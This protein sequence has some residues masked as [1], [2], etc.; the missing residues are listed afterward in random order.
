M[1][2]DR[3]AFRILRFAVFCLLTSIFYLLPNAMSPTTAY[4]ELIATLKRIAVLESTGALL[5]WDERTGMPP[6]AAA[7]RGE[8]LSLLARMTHEQF[9]DPR[10]GE[11]LAACEGTELT[12]DPESDTAANIREIRRDY[13]RATRLPGSLVAE[14]ARMRTL[15]HH[16]W[17][18]AKKASD[19]ASF[20]PTLAR[21][22]EL[23]R[24]EAACY[25]P[26]SGE[27]YDGLLEGYEPGETTA[28]LRAVFASL[29]PALVELVQKITASSRKAPLEILTRHYPIDA[30]AELSRQAAEAVGYDFQ[31]GRI[32]L[33][34][35][36]FSTGI[37]PGDV[38]I[39]TRYDEHYFSDGFFSTLHEVGHALYNQGL[40]AEHF[41][42][43]IGR[44]CSLGIHES[45][46]R[47]W[48]N[49]VGRSRAFWKLFFPRTRA[50][51]PAALEGV[52]EEAWHF[53]INDVRP[54][55]IRT[56]SD[57]LTYNL[58]ILLRFELELELLHGRL[59]TKDLPEAWNAKMRQ[60]LG[61][62][63]GCDREGVLQDVHWSSGAFGYFPTYTLGNLYAAQF[64]EQACGEIGDMDGRVETGD[65]APLLGWLR[66][67][68]HRH[69]RRYTAAQ[70]VERV[71]G[72]PLSPQPLLQHL[73]SKAAELYGV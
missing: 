10:I 34:V 54:S 3:L 25:A 64:F 38:R 47:M 20:E 27:L 50:Q 13:D 52:S 57:E 30:Q 19:Y 18:A 23:V 24:Q 31:A 5:E 21:I 11:L 22:V 66:E 56:E 62:T 43:P 58:H 70:L 48:E 73:R 12:A 17:A 9:T 59:S 6:K 42:T 14:L 16:A 4:A 55:L 29:Q 51:F 15:G 28:N 65:F 61:V 37:A 71:T 67:K 1:T 7:Y 68:I 53:A 49:L 36:P 26:A 60:Y 33:S 46:S 40:P 39:T 44:H 69:G 41:G 63:P 35:H 32:D 2:D 8:Q 72:R 45:Q